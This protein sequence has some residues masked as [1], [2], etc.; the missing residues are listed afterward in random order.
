[1]DV[2]GSRDGETGRHEGAGMEKQGW[3]GRDVEQG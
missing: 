3:E 2:W 1:M